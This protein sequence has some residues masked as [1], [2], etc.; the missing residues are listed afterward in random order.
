MLPVR[1]GLKDYSFIRLPRGDSSFGIF[2]PFLVS[3]FLGAHAGLDYGLDFK[4]ANLTTG[5]V[6]RFKLICLKCLR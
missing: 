3:R 2:T 5:T 1:S 4:R 6:Q